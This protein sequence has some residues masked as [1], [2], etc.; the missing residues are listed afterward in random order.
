MLAPRACHL[1]PSRGTGDASGP[2]AGRQHSGLKRTKCVGDD[3]LDFTNKTSTHIR[4]HPFCCIPAAH[5]VKTGK[6]PVKPK[7]AEH[8]KFLQ[9]ILGR[10]T[11]KSQ[12]LS[13]LSEREYPLILMQR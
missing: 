8:R 6:D 2:Q 3:K 9:Q 11:V 4:N 12:L 7:G 13:H 10:K 5:R 1:H